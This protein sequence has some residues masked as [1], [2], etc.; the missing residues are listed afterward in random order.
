VRIARS[1]GNWYDEE[2]T[3]VASFAEISQLAEVLSA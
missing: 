1:D 3:E 2:D